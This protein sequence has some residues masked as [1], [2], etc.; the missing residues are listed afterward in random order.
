MKYI[1]RE[2]AL[3]ACHPII[4]N[5]GIG[6]IGL[7]YEELKNIGEDHELTFSERMELA[8]RVEDYM[9]ANDMYGSSCNMITVLQTFGL[10]NEA[11]VKEFL[12]ESD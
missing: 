10:L 1:K 3:N 8:E 2:N 11:D 9:E 4:S 12:N 6:T 5:D 7:S